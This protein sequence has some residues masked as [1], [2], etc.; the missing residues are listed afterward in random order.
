MY[1]KIKKLKVFSIN[2]NTLLKFVGLIC[3]LFIFILI[4]KRIGFNL[5]LNGIV[6]VFIYGFLIIIL[7]LIDL[8]SKIVII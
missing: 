1:L 8:K 3:C 2:K 5:V 7:K 6:Y 4:T